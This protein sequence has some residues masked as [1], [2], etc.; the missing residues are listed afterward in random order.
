MRAVL[1]EPADHHADDPGGH[2]DDPHR[3]LGIPEHI[4]E[5]NVLSIVERDDDQRRDEG[6]CDEE[7]Q[8]STDVS[9]L[10]TGPLLGSFITEPAAM[11][12]TALILRDRYFEA[13]A[14]DRFKYVVLATLLVD[15]SIGGVLT[16]FAAPPVLMVAGKWNWDLA[17]MMT[18]FGWKSV[19]AIIVNAALALLLLRTELM[20]LPAAGTDAIKSHVPRWISMIHVL[21]LGLI[22]LF[23][24]DPLILSAI[25]LS[26]L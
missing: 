23:A 19:V 11:T 16:P 5:A 20:A 8:S 22:V 21:I 10:V 24:H 9:C 25:F 17:Y 4:A 2:K 1:Q 15:I 18:T 7:S 13:G 6:G 14:S 12:V 3:R 26:F